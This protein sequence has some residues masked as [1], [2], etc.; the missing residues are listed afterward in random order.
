MG[1]TPKGTPQPCPARTSSLSHAR[2][3]LAQEA[4]QEV[5]VSGRIHEI[6][7]SATWRIPAHLGAAHPFTPTKLPYSGHLRKEEREEKGPVCMQGRRAQGCPRWPLPSKG[8]LPPKG[9]QMRMCKESCSS[10]GKALEVSF[11]ADMTMQNH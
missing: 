4:A 1:A 5:E 8:S 11:A 6:Q 9:R 2:L 7:G 3:C 10:S